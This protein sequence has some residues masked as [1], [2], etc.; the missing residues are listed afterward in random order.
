M[1]L[2]ME[3]AV[4]AM[5]KIGRRRAVWYNKNQTAPLR[6]ERLERDNSMEK[7]YRAELT[8]VFGD[9]VDGNPTGVMEEA[10]Y[11]ALGLNYRYLT[12]RVKKEDLEAAVKGAKAFGMKGY[13]LT[14][15]HKT[16]VIP[17]LDCLT[18]AAEII[19]AVN[20]VVCRNGKWTGE[21][22]DGKGFVLSLKRDGIK[23]EGKR[24]TLLGA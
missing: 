19:G 18:P 7:N 12:L 6:A 5:R 17:Y 14:M 8:A 1:A 15:P 11:E 13:N 9:P 16:A 3:S 20:T 4:C 21:N 2:G 22:T 10:A 23:P 24:I